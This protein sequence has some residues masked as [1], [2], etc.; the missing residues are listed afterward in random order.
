M[1][2]EQVFGGAPGGRGNQTHL[3]RTERHAL[4]CCLWYFYLGTGIKMPPGTGMV[5]GTARPGSRAGEISGGTFFIKKC[6]A[7]YLSLFPRSWKIDCMQ[8]FMGCNHTVRKLKV[9]ACNMT[10]QLHSDVDKT[11]QPGEKKHSG[12]SL[13][14]LWVMISAF[15]F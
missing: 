6:L 8:T 12:Y 2:T 1:L 13:E 3:V 9:H 10:E 7:I 5:P 15:Q 14:N 11:W 4:I